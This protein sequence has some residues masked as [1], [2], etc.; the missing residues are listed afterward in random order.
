MPDTAPDAAP[1]AAA[2]SALA[3]RVTARVLPVND[4]GEVLMLL[5]R[6]PFDTV[7]PYWF[8]IGGGVEA[9]ET[10]EDA[11]VREMREE[12]G[13]AI[14]HDDLVGPVHSGTHRSSS[15]GTPHLTESTYF[16]VRLDEVSVDFGGHQP[17]EAGFITEARWWAPD[18]LARDGRLRWV[19]LLEVM[20]AARH[21]VG[22]AGA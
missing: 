15:G 10:L 18:D 20:R 5:G 9:G 12:T 11:A 6:D 4:A 16:A 1:D 22:R 21:A 7:A 13:I 3:R 14:T 2:N 19:E 8:T 17:D